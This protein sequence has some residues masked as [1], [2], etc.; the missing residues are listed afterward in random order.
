MEKK[1]QKQVTGASDTETWSLKS[2]A[3]LKSLSTMSTTSSFARSFSRLSTSP[4]EFVDL[5]DEEELEFKLVV[6]ATFLE[7][8]PVEGSLPHCKSDSSLVVSQS[9]PPYVHPTD[10]TDLRAAESE[11]ELP[12]GVPSVGSMLHEL[13]RC[14]PCAWFWKPKG[15]AN[16]SS[17]RHCHLCP[18]GELTRQRKVHRCM[19]RQ[20]RQDQGTAQSPETPQVSFVPVLFHVMPR[21]GPNVQFCDGQPVNPTLLGRI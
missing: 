10:G 16:G 4:L 11:T 8:I 20:R 14:R 17:C 6:K 7:Y 9:R 15:C 2:M 3:R 12:E 5:E 19:A 1:L 13:Q 21:M 18:A